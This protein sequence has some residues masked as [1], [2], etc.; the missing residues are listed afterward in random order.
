MTLKLLKEDGLKKLVEAMNAADTRVVGP[1]KNEAGMVIYDEVSQ[2]SQLDLDEIIGRYSPKDAF[3]PQHETVMRYKLDGT[4]VHVEPEKP[5]IKETVLLGVRPCDAAAVISLNSVFT[6]DYIDNLFTERK[7]KVTIISVACNNAD[8]S[9]FCTSVGYAPDGTEGSDILLKK[10][11]EGGYLAEVVTEEGEAL[12]ARYS[13]I[14]LE[15]NEATEIEPIA[16][17]ADLGVSIDKIKAWLDDPKNFEHKVWDDLAA[18]CVGCGGCTFVCPTCH[19]FDLVDEPYG[20][21][22][23]RVK[24]WDGCQFDHFTLHA[25]GH[26]PREHQSQRWRNRFSCKFKIYPDRFEKKGCVGCGRCIRVCP[27]NVDITEAM[28][29]I[30]EMSV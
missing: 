20:D 13:D 25:S 7:K 23:K 15:G 30:S 6:W 14:F 12:V 18:K 28:T 27:V 8:E 10:T 24:N 9:C 2:V 16:E 1:K 17:V 22:G 3:F 4:N 29:E 26:N 19:C 5:T 21:Q 11:K